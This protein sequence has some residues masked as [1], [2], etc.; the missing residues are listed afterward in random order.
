ML[1]TES[2][3][4]S[5]EQIFKKKILPNSKIIFVELFYHVENKF[6]DYY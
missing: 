2:V 5:Q 1:S 3:W 6:D 4:A